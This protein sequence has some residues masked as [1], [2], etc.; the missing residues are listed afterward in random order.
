MEPTDITTDT[1]HIAPLDAD[2]IPNDNQAHY[3]FS[4]EE[5]MRGAYCIAC[6][7]K[8][9][10]MRR[11]V[12]SLIWELITSVTAI[13]GRI[14]RTW[15]TLLFQPG[16]VARD[17]ANGRR[18]YWS[19]PIRVYLA[20]SILL[21]A[22]MGLTNTHL[23]GIDIDVEPKDGIEKVEADLKAED[24]SFKF[25]TKWFPRQKDIDAMNE[26]KNYDLIAL[27]VKSFAAQ[28]IVSSE[29]SDII[30]TV[31]ELQNND[32]DTP[33]RDGDETDNTAGSEDVESFNIDDFNIKIQNRHLDSSRAADV[34]IRFS[35]NPV[36]LTN[37]FNK[38]LPRLIF[39]LMPFTVL[40]SALF[41]RGRKNAMLYDHIVHAAY[42][43]AVA[44]LFLFI[45]IALSQ[46]FPSRMLFNILF[47]ALLIY[48]PLSLKR[49]FKR[50]WFK[51]IWTSYGV[52]FAYLIML[53]T[54]LSIAIIID[55]GKTITI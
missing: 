49:M 4:C 8:N 1:A 10:N 39:I 43:H 29:D 13:E 33:Q 54:S 37:S 12:F 41:I 17:Y 53:M 30:E 23:F 6:G 34:L 3:C 2:N 50:G 11:G 35:R 38:W 26:D 7:Q 28:E 48:L 52:G 5:P 21:F 47:L 16:R 25:S 18:T 24:L 40:F 27:K 44:F 32:S 55:I 46:F 20:M 14:W 45:G 42:L 31:R 36:I 15:R 9:D 22:F 51:T 19:S